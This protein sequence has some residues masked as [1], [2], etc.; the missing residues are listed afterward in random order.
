MDRRTITIDPTETKLRR[1]GHVAR[2]RMR[3]D[4][5]ALRNGT[6]TDGTLTVHISGIGSPVAGVPDSFAWNADRP[7]ALVITRAGVDGEDVRFQ[8]GPARQGAVDGSSLADGSGIRYVAFCYDAAS[9][10]AGGTVRETRVAAAAA[11][12]RAFLPT[13]RERRSI[14]A[15]LLDGGRIRSKGGS[16][17]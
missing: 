16:L 9:H 11:P 12:A 8:V 10:K 3:I 17:A 5:D 2:R 13:G 1:V 14:L 15:L 7:I 4:G 6:H